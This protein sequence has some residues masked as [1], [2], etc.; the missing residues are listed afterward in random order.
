MGRR[1]SPSLP[2]IMLVMVAL[3]A[4]G[5]RRVESPQFQSAFA[6]FN[7]IYSS[8]LDDAYGDP[9]MAQVMKLLH[10]V[11]PKSLDAPEAAELIA[12]IERGQTDFQ[13]RQA[14]VAREEQTVRRPVLWQGSGASTVP[15]LPKPPV[16]PT[17]A[18]GPTL[19]MS[20]DEFLARFASCFL[21]K[22]LYQSGARQGEA[23]GVKPGECATRY[24]ALAD[25]V[26]VLLDNHVSSLVPLSE[27]K[28]VVVDAGAP[29]SAEAPR[30]PPP[31]PPPPPTQT[32][33]YLPGAPVPVAP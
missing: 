7:Q 8:K 27:V 6:L 33:R 17:A 23:Y 16:V 20:R 29:A 13:S 12:R 24:P 2:F 31:A 1:P 22:G 21:L 10:E 9:Q 15:D 25:S 11:D 32:V 18:T 14:A 30:A 19:G 5:H 4:C 26:V 28:T 3:F